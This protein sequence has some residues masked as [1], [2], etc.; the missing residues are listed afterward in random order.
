[1]VARHGASSVNGGRFTPPGAPPIGLY[2]S[3]DGGETFP[4]AF[5]QPS[6]TVNPSSANGSDFFRGGVTN[7][8]FNRTGV[9]EGAPSNVYLSIFDYG[10]YRSDGAGGY[11]Q[12]FASAGAGGVAA[13]LGARTEFALAPHGEG[14]L[15][16]YLGD[17]DGSNPA[18]F[19]R[20]DETLACAGTL[21]DRT[22][23]LGW[24]KLSNPTPGTPGFW[25]Y[26]FCETQC[27]YDM[28]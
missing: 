28:V 17:T 13:S 3:T 9:S 16:I 6:D 18:D 15:R 27:S 25:S 7:V 19:Y 20:V 11:E 2:E 26:D 10:V 1:A 21:T 14:D 5:S 23:N 8:V 24:T 12:I 22:N 4:L